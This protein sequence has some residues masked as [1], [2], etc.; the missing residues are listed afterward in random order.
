MAAPAET[1]MKTRWIGASRTTPC[2]RRMT[3]PSAAKAAFRRP[4][5]SPCSALPNN[6]FE[7]LR[8]ARQRLRQACRVRRP[9]AARRAETAA[10]RNGRR[11]KPANGRRS[12]A[13]SCSTSARKPGVPAPAASRDR[14]E[15]LACRERPATCAASSR[16]G[17]TASRCRRNARSPRW[18]DRAEPR[19]AGPRQDG[20]TARNA[21]SQWSAADHL[22]ARQST[23]LIGDAPGSSAAPAR[24]A[25]AGG[26]A[27]D[28][29]VA[30]LF[31]F[32]REFWAA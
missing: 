26:L 11:R 32:V 27:A 28:P 14:R 23:T 8:R 9:P 30:A 3:A 2:G 22:R 31:Q 16:A 1:A 21:A 13:R 17:S 5:A 7:P 19:Q 29:L 6:D 4:G 20:A 24:T 10:A 18:R 15:R 12:S 25:A